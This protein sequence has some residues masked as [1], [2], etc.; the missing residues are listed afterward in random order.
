[1]AFNLLVLGPTAALSYLNTIWFKLVIVSVAMVIMS[2]V[3]AALTNNSH[4]LSLA[5]IAA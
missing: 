2:V 3:T 5:V 4:R 1:M